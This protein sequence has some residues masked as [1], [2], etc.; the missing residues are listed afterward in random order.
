MQESVVQVFALVNGHAA[1]L[2]GLPVED[3]I[4]G[5]ERTTKDGT[6]NQESSARRLR[7]CGSSRSLLVVRSTASAA[8][9]LESIAGG[10]GCDAR[11]EE[12]GRGLGLDVEASDG[13]GVA[14]SSL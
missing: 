14:E 7:R 8:R 6:S 4:D 12:V 3:S 5:N 9:S 10:C 1:I 13:C 11:C 2:T